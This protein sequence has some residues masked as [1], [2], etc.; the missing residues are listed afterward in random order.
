MK[1]MTVKT[2]RILAAAGGAA[3]VLALL[4]A[5][6]AVHG[7]PVS[8][9]W[10]RQAAVRYAEKLYPG[11]TFAPAGVTT[12]VQP[13]GYDTWVQSA[14]SPDTR[15][16]VRTR[17]WLFTGDNCLG[18]GE[19]S[20]VWFVE[21]KRNTCWRLEQEAA[22]GLTALARERYGEDIALME[23]NACRP[24]VFL[25][26]ADPPQKTNDGFTNSSQ[27]IEAWGDGLALDEPMAPAALQ[28]TPALLTA[29]RLCEDNTLTAA[30]KAQALR[31]LK[32]FVESAGWSA[33]Y[34]QV[35]FLCQ[36]EEY[37]GLAEFA[38]SEAIPSD[39]L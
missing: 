27:N 26:C 5:V 13:L 33:D 20:H 3:I 35:R 10:A 23:A 7:D 6:D 4:L 31:E 39:E 2:K 18:T 32:A 16:P 34:Y 29:C 36:S 38:V 22:D 37:Y 15:F 28:K 8:R 21:Q 24:F 25:L 30:E 19:A 14:Q 12:Y 17:A 9:A 11:Q 1:T